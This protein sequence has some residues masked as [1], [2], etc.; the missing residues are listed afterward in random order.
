MGHGNIAALFYFHKFYIIKR[1][2]YNDLGKLPAEG[3]IT[4]Y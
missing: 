2:K 3:L 4:S 1:P